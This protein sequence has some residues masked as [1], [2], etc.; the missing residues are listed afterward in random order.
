[1]TPTELAQK[2]LHVKPLVSMVNEGGTDYHAERYTIQV[3]FG[4]DSYH[5]ETWDLSLGRKLYDGDD[6]PA[7]KAAVEADH[8]AR[9]AAM[10]EE[11]PHDPT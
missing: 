8:A 9:I 7:A 2:G 5:F 10:I 6:L 4:S 11:T 1:M 3:F